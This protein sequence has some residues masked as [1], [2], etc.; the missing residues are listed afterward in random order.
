MLAFRI[1]NVRDF[2]SVSATVRNADV[3]INAA[4]LK[5]VTTCGYFPYQAVETNIG[6]SENIVRAI[7]EHNLSV[8]TVIGISTDK[9]C[10]PVNVMGMTKAIQERVLGCPSYVVYILVLAHS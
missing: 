3:V 6:G 10:K 7:R 8:E 1:G 5:Q 2:H 9:A 4:A